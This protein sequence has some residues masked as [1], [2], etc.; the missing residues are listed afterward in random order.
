MYGYIP[1]I[2]EDKITQSYDLAIPKTWTFTRNDLKYA[3]VEDTEFSDDQKAEI[4][5][6]GGQWFATAVEF[7]NWM[8]EPI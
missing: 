8:N 5:R 2:N 4:E 7:M 1:L 6:L 3:G